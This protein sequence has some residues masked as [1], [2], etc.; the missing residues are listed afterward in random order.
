MATT[1][2]AGNK[3]D[4]FELPHQ[5]TES[6]DA[7]IE[8]LMKGHETIASAVETARARNARVADK[9]FAAV[10]ES[11]RDALQLGKLVASEPTAYAKNLEAMMQSMSTAQ[12]RALDV[13]KTV[14]REQAEATEELRSVAERA[15]EG[16]KAFTPPLEQFTG[17]WT[18]A[19]K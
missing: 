3:P 10:L 2:K 12:E 18:P 17:M 11:Q 13:A 9:F 4:Q 8:R 15:F 1:K 7:Y 5:F 14:Y 16:V 6:A 19:A